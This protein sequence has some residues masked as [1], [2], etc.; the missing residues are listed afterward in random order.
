MQDSL[1]PMADALAIVFEHVSVEA[2]PVRILD[3]VDLELRAGPP[4]VVL[5]PNGSGKSTLLKLA[6]GLVAPTTGAVTLRGAAARP[7]GRALVF[8]KPV[9]LRRTV[10]ENIAFAR[11]AVGLPAAETDV[12]HLLALTHVAGLANRPARR[13]SGGEQQRVALARALAR[14]PRILLLDE[15]TAS[16]DPAST[17]LVEQIIARV[18]A[19]GV[20]IVMSTHDIGQARR[21]GR[22]VVF[23]AG[24]R[25]IEHAPAD[26]FFAA[27]ASAEARSFLAG[28][29]LV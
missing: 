16:L 6:M 26:R 13:L 12:R 1:P 21:I 17:K 27:P 3:R 2:G 5:G 14:E 28:E 8:Q 20:K 22:E 11:R 15:P 25:V 4:T 29:L 18:A 24:G 10:A 9:M 19:D 7:G 23:L